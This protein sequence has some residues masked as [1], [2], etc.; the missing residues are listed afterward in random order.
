MMRI[1]IKWWINCI[2]P[3]QN[4]FF[5]LSSSSNRSTNGGVALPHPK[6]SPSL[7]QVTQNIPLINEEKYYLTTIVGGKY[8]LYD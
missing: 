5:F 8:I 3:L 6:P 1:P 4:I 7:V 2:E